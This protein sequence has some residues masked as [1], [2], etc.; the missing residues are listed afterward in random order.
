VSYDASAWR[1][2]ALR[3]AAARSSRGRSVAAKAMIASLEKQLAK[4]VTDS[5]H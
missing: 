3:A 4:H 1:S 5:L 2:A